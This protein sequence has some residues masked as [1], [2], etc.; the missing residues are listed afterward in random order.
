MK[1][2]VIVSAIVVSICLVLFLLVVM[3][4]KETNKIKPSIELSRIAMVDS[5]PFVSHGKFTTKDFIS[6]KYSGGPMPY[7]KSIESDSGFVPNEKTAARMAMILWSAIY[8]EKQI[9]SEFPFHITLVDD[10]LWSLSGSVNPVGA[11]GGAAHL[12]LRKSDGKVLFIIH[13]K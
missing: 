3:N 11:I 12:L 6:G 2:K 5:I 13:E 8:G 1:I 7:K 9:R 4:K 10:T